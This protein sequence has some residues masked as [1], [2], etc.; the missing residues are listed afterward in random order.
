M[1]KLNYYTSICILLVI[2]NKNLTCYKTIGLLIQVQK[3][4]VHLEISKIL[5]G[6]FCYL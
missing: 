2:Y 4:W 6:K 5:E 3:I 1:I